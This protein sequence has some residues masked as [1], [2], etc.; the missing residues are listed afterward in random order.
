MNRIYSNVWNHTLGRLVVAS[1]LARHRA[2]S[3]RVVSR[4]GL[5]TKAL[6]ALVL[7]ACTGGAMAV[8]AVCVDPANPGTPVGQASGVGD[9][10]AC[11][12]GAVASGGEA[13]AIGARALGS[14]TS[15]VAVGPDAQATTSS[16]V[17]VGDDARAT[18]LTAT[19]IGFGTRAA[20]EY[21]VALGSGAQALGNLSY[22]LGNDAQAREGDVAVGAGALTGSTGSTQTT[23]IG[24]NSGF[25]SLNAAESTFIGATA[26]NHSNGQ[27]NS[28]IGFGTGSAANGNRNVYSG[29]YTGV[30]AVGNFNI[31]SGD[32]ALAGASGNH[33]VVQGTAAGALVSGEGNVAI[34]YLAGTMVEVDANGDPDPTTL[35]PVLYNN[36]VNIGS[37]T[38]ALADGAIAIGSGAESSHAGSVALG[39][40]SL[41]NG[42]TLGNQ[43]YAPLD[44]NGAPVV[45]AGLNP[46]GEVS[47]GSTGNERRVTNVAAGAN[48]T[49]AVNVS[50]LRAVEGVASAGWNVT[51]VDG[52]EVNI[53]PNGKVTFESGNDNIAVSQTGAD[54]DGV[55]DIT[56]SNDLDLTAAGSLTIGDTLVNG[57]GVVIGADVTLGNTGLV[58]NGGPSVTVAGI[59][60]G[61]A[62]ITNVAA[63]VD[64]T[65]AVN[66][67][68]LSDAID[69]NRSRY[70]SV[71][72]SGGG[73][74]DNDGA[75]G[76]NAIA[77]GRD[78]L[79]QGDEAVALGFA[80]SA[81]GEGS[82][83]VGSSAQASLLNTIAIGSGATAMH[84]NSIAFGAGSVTTVGAQASYQGAYVGTSSS[85]GE[86]NIG[87]RQVT[88]VAAGSA[89]TDAVNVSQLQGGVTQ[90]VTTAN[91]YTDTQI[92]NVNVAIGNLDNRVTAIEG[93]LV[94]IRGDIT[95]IRGD[96]VDI[97]GD[98]NDLGDR[99]TT[100][101]GDVAGLTTTV[102][103]FDNRI[104]TVE[105]DVSNVQ[106]GAD[107][108]FQISQEGPVVKPVPT[109]TN[110]AA[111]GNGAVASGNH[112]LAVGNQSTAGGAN[113]TALGTGASASATGS[114]AVGQGASATHGNSV[115][116][117]AGSATTV[118]AQA[119]YNA[120]YVG[121][122]TSTG[123]VNVGGRTISGVAPGIAGTDAVNVNQLS[124]GVNR[125]VGM[126]NQYTDQRLGELQNDMWTM[127]R[128]YR[129]ATASAMAMAGLPQAYLPGK[130]MLAVGI[131][132]YQSEYGMAVGLSG[133]TDN[134]RYVYKASASGN[135]SRDWGFSV[136]AG[137]QW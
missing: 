13:I 6:A 39:S 64:D 40:G 52:N 75:T 62:V 77:A 82:V 7:A 128:G 54:D 135:T 50:Q 85:T 73:N 15:A 111:G 21:S 78:T 137:I 130:N 22:A 71:N 11:G 20:G 42:S 126:A 79:A 47:V 86:M 129:G 5:Q 122:S 94:D 102:D 69:A 63:G 60:A 34:G 43:A 76:A 41:A 51:D 100:V 118:G 131:G 97:Q 99:V 19:A 84:A 74:Q 124:A 61:N 56:L 103:A 59:D 45:V 133:I 4:V 105:G 115:A 80:A 57:T 68:Q 132:G 96:I 121:D 120:A 18:G 17:A 123:E 28:Y 23:A 44:E 107:G 104:V 117:G 48:A 134:G 26:G 95:D 106:N 9:N 8:D 72:S 32:Y 66:V 10:V 87:G 108:M 31:A 29:F 83:A 98:V 33:N 119:N 37:R 127:N 125:A 136:G 55:V 30:Q 2:G 67:S 90:A 3:R 25:E 91:A 1:E 112:A 53:G 81:S 46:V 49:D 110:A 38:R 88:G 89:D 16:A 12:Q 70:Y 65:D 93:D 14:G 116:L 114:T 113:S 27:Q 109:G 92:G 36:A 58:I 35:A 24:F 101:E